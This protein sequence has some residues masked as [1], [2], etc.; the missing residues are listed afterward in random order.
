VTVPDALFL[1][2][3]DRFVPTELARGPWSPDAL[4]GGPPAALLARALERAEG[5]DAVQVTRLTVELLRP[6]PFAP[7]AVQARVTRPGRKVQLVEAALA[8]GDAV[9]AR[10]TALRIR[11]S[12]L[13]LP[14]GLDAPAPP[15]GPAAGAPTRLAWGAAGLPAFHS[16]AVEHRFVTGGFDRPGAATDWIR[17]RVPLVAGE[18]ASP[19]VR[20]A[21]AADF[22]NGISWVLDRQDGWRFINPDLTVYLHRLP[23]GEWVCL[24]ALT[25]V[26][27]HGIGFAESRL[28]DERG[29]LGRA[30]Q[31][32]LVERD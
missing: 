7:L 1:P 22:G 21:A 28:W 25:R 9:V 20:V 30:L 32:L 10:A 5:G 13:V 11:R 16:H 29:L 2:D 4:H 19:L 26:E 31:S 15:P 6:V 12:D 3:G 17:L 14:P 18:P 23:A 8:S 24:E 27:P